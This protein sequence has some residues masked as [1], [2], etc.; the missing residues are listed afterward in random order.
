MNT[1]L[2]L[3]RM[4]KLV[5][6]M[7]SARFLRALVRHGVLVCADH[8]QVL[9]PEL[10]TVVDI[11][12]NRGQFAL[13]AKKWAPN[14]RIISFEP[15]NDAAITFRK[16]FKADTA[17]RL[18]QAAIGPQAGEMVIHVSAADDSSSLL[19]VSSLQVQLFPGT[20]TIGH[21][22]IK[23]GPLSCFVTPRAITA[24][25]MLK[26]DVQGYELQALCGCEELLD[27]F[28]FIYVECSFVALYTG[29]ALADEVIAWLGERG[30]HLGGIYNMTYDRGGRSVQADFLFQTSTT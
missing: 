1:S 22:K 26:L 14:A 15:L 21:E 7:R 12:A 6:A 5:Q 11:G 3:T 9:T 8:R 30:W 16:V 23:A 18:I 27:R 4:D 24:P 29:Q 10:L 2:F 19:P 13:A 28:T 17:V 20:H 25:A